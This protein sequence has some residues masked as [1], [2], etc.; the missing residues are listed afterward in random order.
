MST[1]ASHS[2]LHICET[3]KR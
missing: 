1:F 2:P 3:V